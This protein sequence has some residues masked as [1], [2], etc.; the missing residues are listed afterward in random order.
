LAVRGER[1]EYQAGVEEGR[2]PSSFFPCQS[3]TG[4]N[5]MVKIYLFERGTK[6]LKL[7]N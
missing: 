4:N 5:T 1:G 6:G 3:K 7:E 2:N